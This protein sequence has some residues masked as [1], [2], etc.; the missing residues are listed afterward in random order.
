ML[1]VCLWNCRGVKYLKDQSEEKVR[2]RY[3]GIHLHC[4]RMRREGER[5]NEVQEDWRS[6]G[7]IEERSIRY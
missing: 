6:I 4:T 3:T 2:G 1:G 5:C 7:L